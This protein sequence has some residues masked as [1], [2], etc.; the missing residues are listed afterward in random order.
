MKEY[1]EYIL[2]ILTF[3]IKEKEKR[4]ED[5]FFR[6]TDQIRCADFAIVC[7]FLN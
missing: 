1:N 2:K 5:W 7:K 4:E 3:S 6:H